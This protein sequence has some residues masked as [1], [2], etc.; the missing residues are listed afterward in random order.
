MILL[1]TTIVFF[2]LN[3]EE[4]LPSKTIARLTHTFKQRSLDNI[5]RGRWDGLWEVAVLIIRD[6]PLTG[7]KIG[8]YIIEASNYGKIYNTKLAP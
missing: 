8:G 3:K 2:R 6:Y 5:L 7:L 4:K 1:G